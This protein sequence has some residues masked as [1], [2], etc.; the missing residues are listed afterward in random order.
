MFNGSNQL[1][2]IF[3]GKSNMFTESV[4]FS[5]TAQYFNESTRFSPEVISLDLD[6]SE[7]PRFSPKVRDFHRSSE[8]STRSPR[9]LP[10]VKIFVESL[11]CSLKV[12]IFV[13]SQVGTTGPCCIGQCFQKKQL[14]HNIFYPKRRKSTPTSI[15]ISRH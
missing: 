1:R 7:S 10:K 9:Y 5:Q 8:N 14:A 11:R 3:E 13:K 12:E 2:F 15:H 4:I 6:L